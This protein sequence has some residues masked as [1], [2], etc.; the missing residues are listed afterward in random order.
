MWESP[1]KVRGS[2]VPHV[3]A[4][5]P[6]AEDHRPR[7]RGP[8]LIDG[9]SQRE[10]GGPGSRAPKPAVAVQTAGGRKRD[11]GPALV[12]TSPSYHPWSGVALGAAMPCA[13]PDRREGGGEAGGSRHSRTYLGRPRATERGRVC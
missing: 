4:K 9:R 3:S 8:A 10:G 5:F 13:M 2:R 6:E 1:L 11:R 7:T 12:A